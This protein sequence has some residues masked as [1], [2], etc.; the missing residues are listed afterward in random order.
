LFQASGLGALL[1]LSTL[2]E[3]GAQPTV[4]LAEHGLAAAIAISSM[5]TPSG[6]RPARSV[7]VSFAVF[8][9]L[10]CA[11]AAIAPY[12][13]AAFLTCWELVAFTA[14]AWAAAR[15][16]DR[17]PESLAPWLAA[18]IAAHGLA[19]LGER[20]LGET[21]PATTFFNTN[22]LAAWLV[23]ASFVV[24]GTLPEWTSRARAAGIL[25]IA[26]GVAAFAA[27]GSR[28]AVL[29][30]AASGAVWLAASPSLDRRRLRIAIVVLAA[31]VTA[32]AVGAAWRFATSQ[33]P[34]AFQ[35]I[36]IWRASTGALAEDPLFGTG[37]GQFRIAASHLNFPLERQTLRYAR[38][39]PTPHSDLLRAACE[40]GIPAAVAL[41]VTLGL[42]V[43]GTVRRRREGLLRG[44][45]PAAAAALAGLLTQGALDDLTGRPALYLLAAALVGS[46]VAA[47]C[48]RSAP[49]ESKRARVAVGAAAIL[50]FLVLDVSPWLAWRAEQDLPG[51]PAGARL[52]IVDRA[53]GLNPYVASLWMRRAE[54]IAGAPDS[55]SIERYAFARESAEQAMRLSPADATLVKG[56]ARI[57][58]L[59]CRTFFP[60]V[61]FRRQVARRFELVE[62]LAP[63]D[64][65][66]T[67]E[68][69][70]TILELGDPGGA[71]AAAARAEAIE[72]RAA[73]P[74][75]LRA[76]ALAA[77]G[78]AAAARKELDAAR[79]LAAAG[80]P[81][82]GVSAYHAGLLRLPAGRAEALEQR[83][84]STAS[85]AQTP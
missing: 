78:N 37:P 14:I 18:G 70:T 50:G 43:M 81:E 46:L 39:F 35:R 55:W 54:V 27:S 71:A 58:A 12:G 20:L 65:F 38:S 45:S 60:V 26:V 31:A 3:G 23:A 1:L 19:A 33:D 15:C 49:L 2:G 53:L 40:F 64:A 76:E 57:D 36:D 59:A 25:A 69:A 77:Q 56:A 10:A 11:S 42:V 84:D 17:L 13:Y 82:A 73:A 72:P 34:F 30:V 16:G 41:A 52:A 5:M 63:H 61:A 74:R 51:A 22:H 80:A 21:R 79:A 66:A 28:G 67:M 6:W 85:P 44:A 83:L 24:G 9:A 29:A 48:E 62:A 68:E 47:R 32:G 4:Q 7:V 8:L 75:L